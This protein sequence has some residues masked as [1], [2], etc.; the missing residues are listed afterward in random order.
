MFL[1]LHSYV[2][3][4][5]YIPDS[6]AWSTFYIHNSNSFRSIYNW[7]TVVTYS[8]PKMDMVKSTKN[9]ISCLLHTLLLSRQLRNKDALIGWWKMFLH[10]LFTC[11]N[12][13]HCNINI[14]CSCN[15][16]SISIRAFSWC[17][18]FKVRSLNIHTFLKNQMHLLRI[19]YL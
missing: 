18:H 4:C 10:D 1:K 16:N 12:F 11:F 14:S 15:M 13:R 3:V 19:L 6:M 2:C 7:N 9:L 17:C 5:I 8:K